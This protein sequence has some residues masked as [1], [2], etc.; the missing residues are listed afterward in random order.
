MK[1]PHFLELLCFLVMGNVTRAGID[2]S[3]RNST[4]TVPNLDAIEA[5]KGLIS[6]L[7]NSTFKFDNSSSTFPISKNPGRSADI[8]VEIYKNW[9]N[10]GFWVEILEGFKVRKWI[11]D[12][13]LKV[14][15][16]KSENI[17]SFRKFWQFSTKKLKR[18]QKLLIHVNYMVS[19]GLRAKN[20]GTFASEASGPQKL[21]KLQLGGN[22]KVFG[23]GSVS[24]FNRVR[25]ISW[26]TSWG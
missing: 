2:P 12:D 19:G 24:H 15:K 1:L 4:E 21:E 7:D 9:G 18:F 14:W 3:R 20:W 13:N 22:L 8:W 6:I 16:R 23:Y 11:L 10:F 17:F 26:S 25:I 5:G